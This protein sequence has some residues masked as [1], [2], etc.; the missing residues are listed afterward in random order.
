MV[1]TNQMFGVNLTG[2]GSNIWLLDVIPPII[3]KC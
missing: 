3:Q 2:M 1:I